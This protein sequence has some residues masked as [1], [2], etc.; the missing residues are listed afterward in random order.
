M[1]EIVFFDTEVQK[2]SGHL[3]DIGA[4][5]SQGRE[6]HTPNRSEFRDFIRDCGFVCGHNIFAHDLKFVGDLIRETNGR[7]YFIDT[8]YLSP[9]LFPKR[10]YHRLLKDDKLQSD[11]LNNPVNDSKKARDLFYDE[12]NAFRALPA[13]MKEIFRLLLGG[14][15]EFRG[16]FAFLDMHR[17]ITE[18]TSSALTNNALSRAVY[19]K[20]VSTQAAPA[21]TVHTQAAPAPTEEVDSARRFTNTVSTHSLPTHAIPEN[22]NMVKVTASLILREFSGRICENADLSSMIR[23]APVEL[24]YTLSLI[25]VDDK[26][27]V[28]PPWV[29][30][31]YPQIENV[32]K[33]LRATPCAKGCPYCRSRLNVRA[34]LKDFFG[35]DSFRTYD[36]EPLQEKAAAAAVAGRSLLAVFPTGG[37]K[38]I[39]FQLP[40]LIAGETS[41]GLTVVISPLQSLMKDQVDNLEERGI[42]DAVTINGLLDAVERG[43]AIERVENGIA[44]ILYISPESLRS[45][46]IERLLLSRN[47]VRFVIDEAHCFSAWGQDFRVDYLYIG[48]FIRR[49][50]EKKNLNHDIPVS[51]F[52]AT[53]KQKV[54]RDICDYF[55]DK[56]GLNLELFTTSATRK[57]LHYSV[58]FMEDENEKYMTARR[59]LEAKDCPAIIYVSRVKKT[60]EISKRLAADGFSALPYNGQMERSEKVANQNAFINGEARVIV[61]TSAFG[62]GVDKKDVGLVIHYEISDSLE[63]YVQE[64]GRAGRDPSILADCYVLFSNEDLDKHFILLNQTKLSMSEIQQVWKAVKDLTKVRSSFSASALEIA[65]AAGWGEEKHDIETHVRS[66]LAALE[67]AGYLRREQNVPHV[68]ADSLL[69]ANMAEA[70]SRIDAS[71]RFTLAQRENAKR[72]IKFILSRKSISRGSKDDAET[73]VDYI[74]DRLGLPKSDVIDA[75]NL[76]REEHILADHTDLTAFLPAGEKKNRAAG[77]LTRFQ[78]LEEYLIVNL[79]NGEYFKYKELNDQAVREGVSHSTVKDIKTIVFFWTITGLLRKK[80][81]PDDDRVYLERTAEPALFQKRLRKRIG[82]SHFIIEYL[83]AK[84]PLPGERQDTATR[85][86]P[87]SLMELK[88]EYINSLPLIASQLKL[89]GDDIKDA[90]LYLSKIRA[91]T[92]EGGFFV[93]YNAMQIKRLE[94]DNRIK[95]KLDDYRQLDDFYRQRIQQIHIVGEF[96]NLMV[97]DYD[98]ALQFVSDYF[99]IDHKDFLDKYFKGDRQKEIVRNIT[100]EKYNRLFGG[101]SPLQRQIIDDDRSKYIVVAA[102]PGSGKTMLLVHKLASLTMLED[103]KSDQLLM[104]TFSRA[105]ATEFKTRLMELIGNAAHYITIKTFHSYC[106][107]LLGR[108]GTLEA[109]E[110]VV[111][112]AVAGIEKGEIEPRLITKSVLVIDE[113]QDMDEHEFALVKGLMKQNDMMR[114]IAVGDDDQN[115]YEFRG[116]RSAYMFSLIKDYGAMRY[117]MLDNYRSKKNIITLSNAFSATICGRMKTT[118]IRPACTESR[119]VDGSSMRPADSE[120]RAVDGSSTQ[121]TDSESRAVD[122]NPIQPT[123]SEGRAVDGSSIRLGDSENGLVVITTYRSGNLELPLCE[124]LRKDRA[125]DIHNVRKT[126]EITSLTNSTAKLTE[127]GKP[128]SFISRAV[129]TAT[130]EEAFRV[131]GLLLNSGIPAKLVQSLTGFDLNDLA[132]LRYFTDILKQQSASPVIDR[133]QW[134]KAKDSLKNV[135]KTS[136]ILP[137]CLRVITTFERINRTLYL[138][139]FI[140]FLLESKLDDFTVMDDVDTAGPAA[141]GMGAAAPCAGSGTV[142]VSTFHKAKGRQFDAVYI[143]LDR[144]DFSSDAAKRAAYVGITRAKSYLSIHTNSPF[145]D[146]LPLPSD[147]VIRRADPAIYPEPDELLLELGHRDVFL[148]FYKGMGHAISRL[149]SGDPLHID[150]RYLSISITSPGR[151]PDMSPGMSSDMSFDMSSDMSHGMSLYMSSGMSSDMS[152]G[153]CVGMSAGSPDF[154]RIVKFSNKFWQKLSELAAKGYKPIRAEVRFLVYWKGKDDAVETLILLPNI[155]LRK[156]R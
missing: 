9:L 81:N 80:H 51:C 109:A 8:L 96:A 63:N 116:S 44:S 101:L 22:D 152:H 143:L 84:E 107:D 85:V 114:V 39:T 82:L 133:K 6:I 141:E 146:R 134:D 1:R 35:F 89:S 37:G 117:E 127:S 76:M 90:L 10:P 83:Y 69:V 88:N 24:A 131:M 68:Y 156:L 106:F 98:A 67:Q 87:F 13:S 115:I 65:R 21:H 53:A 147:S 57:N 2:H 154:C 124:E 66:A 18:D 111:P 126:G 103:V 17:D 64:A 105:A 108:P 95:Y 43:N 123:D 40:A 112:D 41:R 46:S 79:P 28:T 102:G 55:Q 38:S 149:R 56:L 92:L 140:E 52:T 119:A 74:A 132:E 128:R 5:N 155:F 36:G 15:Q 54:I 99:Q 14:R 3:F 48:D 12:V 150:G 145:F 77:I 78:A 71:D 32:V 62:M 29:I 110:N 138:Q 130:N 86:I 151:S 19:T 72:S 135:F 94:T 148:D 100:G 136:S 137:V 50:R 33:L 142:L 4:V 120:S 25:H 122:N 16:F 61:A 42:A 30:R 23:K 104:L 97:R 34:Q 49:L 118:P 91:L 125:E 27:S 121:P 58:L 75:V 60:L 139:D 70:A 31:N 93:V 73:R 144:Y 153:M 47:V 7:C 20:T 59:L 26:S 45:K 129:L 113:A 11:D